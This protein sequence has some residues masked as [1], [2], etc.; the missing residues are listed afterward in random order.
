MVPT[1][2]PRG[3]PRA[4]RWGWTSRPPDQTPMIIKEIGFILNRFKRR[5]LAAKEYPPLAPCNNSVEDV[6]D[7][8]SR[9]DDDDVD[10]DVENLGGDKAAV[11]LERGDMD[12]V[13]NHH[14]LSKTIMV[15]MLNM[16]TSKQ[17]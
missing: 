13:N 16:I 1:K 9:D 15:I 10:D 6:D 3:Q 17:N 12:P 5:E 4:M 11:P 7:G 2:E 8:S 14:H